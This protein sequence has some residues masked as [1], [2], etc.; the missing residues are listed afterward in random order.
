M[1]ELPGNITIRVNVYVTK[2]EGS[3]QPEVV[4]RIIRE[5]GYKTKLVMDFIDDCC[6][7]DTG[8]EVGATVLY[9]AFIAYSKNKKITRVLSQKKFG[10]IVGR[11]FLREKCGIKRYIGL[12]LF[13]NE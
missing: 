12:G 3:C 9:D 6:Y 4:T 11:Y 7:Q 10:R 2:E 8:A 1:E 5:S 13:S